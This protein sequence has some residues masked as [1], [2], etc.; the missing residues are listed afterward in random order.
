VKHH[1][2]ITLAGTRTTTTDVYRWVQSLFGFHARIA[3]RFARSEPRRRVLAYLQGIL[4]DTSRKNG[5]Q[6]AEHAGEARPDDEVDGRRGTMHSSDLP[7]IPSGGVMKTALFQPSLPEPDRRLSTH[8]ALQ[9]DDSTS[10]GLLRHPPHPLGFVHLPLRP[11]TLSWAL[12]QAFDY[13]DRS[14]TMSLSAWR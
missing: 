6:L 11:F 3:P 9:G 4:S 13:Y 7:E 14:V 2:H 5:W 10:L 8:P 1:Q 12:P